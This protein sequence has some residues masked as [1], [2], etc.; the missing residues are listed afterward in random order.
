MDHG[1]YCQTCGGY[2]PEMTVGC[3][4]AGSPQPAEQPVEA[5]LP[6]VSGEVASASLNRFIVSHWRSRYPREVEGARFRIPADPAHDDDLLLSRYIAEREKARENKSFFS[7]PFP[8]GTHT[9]QD[10]SGRRWVLEAHHLVLVGDAEARVA[11]QAQARV[12]FW[13]GIADKRHALLEEIGE[14]V[15]RPE[16]GS[17]IAGFGL[18]DKAPECIRQLTARVE[19]MENGIR[20]VLRRAAL[21]G[22]SL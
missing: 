9:I 11:E 4:T 15:R 21:L 16:D 18:C 17:A 20:E 1:R 8:E 2:H 3:F 12:S 7:F 6:P 14:A 5:A 19:E 10:P 22:L 13:E